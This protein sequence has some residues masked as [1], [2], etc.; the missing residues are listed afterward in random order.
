MQG[1]V[2]PDQPNHSVHALD[3]PEVL[4]LAHALRVLR[5]RQ[6]ATQERVTELEAALRQA[7][8]DNEL[9]GREA[10]STQRTLLALVTGRSEQNEALASARR[11][12]MG[13]LSPRFT[14]GSRVFP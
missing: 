2:Q 6:G 12:G 14:D 1:D 13:G 3:E 5:A 11:M 10:T 9:A 8:V 7:H 4:R